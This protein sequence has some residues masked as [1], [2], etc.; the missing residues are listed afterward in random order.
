MKK[1]YFIILIFSLGFKSLANPLPSPIVE[2]SELYFDESG[3]WKLELSYDYFYSDLTNIDSLIIYS[4]TDTAKLTSIKTPVYK[5]VFVVTNDS[6]NKDFEINRFGD[7]ILIKSYML[8]DVWGS[9]DELIFGEKEGA[10]INYPKSGQSIT[11]YNYFFVKDNSPTIGEFN[12]D[13]GITGTLK[14][15]IYDV[16]SSPVSNRQF[17]I[18]YDFKFSTNENGEFSTN[19]Y[20]KPYSIQRILCKSDEINYK[21][22]SIT[23]IAYNLEPDSAVVRDIYLQDQLAH[24]DDHFIYANNPVKIWPNPVKQGQKL[25]IQIDLPVKTADVYTGLYDVNGKLI[26]K[27]KITEEESWQDMPN[28]SGIYILKVW[29]DDAEI[30]NSKI[31]VVNE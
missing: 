1:I 13:T 27:E 17:Y 31:V 4:S 9:E 29:L 18:D 5:G 14:G 22:A 16:Y 25:H 2:I 19:I 23:P 15:I 28:E 26:K 20:A 12:D 10:V 24:T 7:D 8:Y 21:W 3:N 11:R 6:L 30:S